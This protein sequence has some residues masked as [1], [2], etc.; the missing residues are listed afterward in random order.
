[1]DAVPEAERKAVARDV[2]DKI[3][4]TLRQTGL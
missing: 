4:A 1:M 3:L 2:A